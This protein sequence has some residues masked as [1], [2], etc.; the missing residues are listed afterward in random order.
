MREAASTKKNAPEKVASGKLLGKCPQPWAK[1]GTGWDGSSNT[2]AIWSRS[3][4]TGRSLWREW[5]HF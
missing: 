1:V 3:C 2:I 4:R 5:R